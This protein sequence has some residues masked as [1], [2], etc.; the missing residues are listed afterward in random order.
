MKRTL[1]TRFA[2][3]L[4]RSRHPFDLYDASRC[5]SAQAQRFFAKEEGRKL[6]YVYGDAQILSNRFDIRYDVA[7]DIFSGLGA[8][9][10]S[11][12]ITR[13]LA[14]RMLRHLARTGKVNWF[15][16]TAK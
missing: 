4:E 13:A 14:V 9:S 12:K 11:K 15:E 8:T 7:H 2:D 1:L 10:D 6:D 3:W 5:M 16:A